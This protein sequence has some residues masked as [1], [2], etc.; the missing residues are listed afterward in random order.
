MLKISMPNVII[1]NVGV[2]NV[3]LLNTAMMSAVIPCVIT[4]K[5]VASDQAV[6]PIYKPTLMR[7]RICSV[8]LFI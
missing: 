4:L 6:H 8:K 5:A 2:T 1:L 3:A 7:K